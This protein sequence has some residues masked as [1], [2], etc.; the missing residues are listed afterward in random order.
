MS[1]LEFSYNPIRNFAVANEDQKNNSNLLSIN[2]E[3]IKPLENFTITE[4]DFIK[5]EILQIR[6]KEL[7]LLGLIN[8]LGEEVLALKKKEL[9]VPNSNKII[10][11]FSISDHKKT[12]EARYKKIL[13]KTEKA[14]KTQEATK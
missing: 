1:K 8:Y 2:D 4:A 14:T 11:R 6:L 3:K 9:E 12:I 13:T 5:N 7:E 10:E